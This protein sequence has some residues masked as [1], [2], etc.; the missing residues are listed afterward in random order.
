[1][2]R[3]YQQV[4]ESGD[5]GSPWFARMA[6]EYLVAGDAVRALEICLVG[7][8]EFPMYT[9]GLLLLARALEASGRRL[10]AILEYR[11]VLEVHPGNRSVR[12]LLERIVKQ[13]ADEFRAFAE[14]HVPT[15]TR[16]RDSVT[17]DAFVA[18]NTRG[19]ESNV[20]FL[21]KQL[22]EVRKSG[23]Q[24]LAEEQPDELRDAGEA[25]GRIVTET[26][27]EIYVSQHEYR[28]AM[29]AYR[30][31]LEQRPEEA[32]KY[33]RRITELEVLTRTQRND[34]GE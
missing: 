2:A 4:K 28:E 32:E 1:M 26:L 20:D 17:A 3:T 13:E 27:A 19:G 14:R 8:R 11:R 15:L 33:Q 18:A 10:A 30:R 29:V 21:L 9:T 12:M 31:L 25:P 24:A 34:I 7:R 23:K 6:A 5:A 16:A 22:G